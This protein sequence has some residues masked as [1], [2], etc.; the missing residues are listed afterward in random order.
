MLDMKINEIEKKVYITFNGYIST[1][2]AKSFLNK[3]KQETKGIKKSQYK[4]VVKPSVFE[5]ESEE[6]VKDICI[7]L[8][9]SGYQKI[10]MLD[11]EGY[12]F[13]TVPMSSFEKKMLM[14][15]VKFVKSD[16]EIK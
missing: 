14:K 6:D 5:C 1:S 16:R 11:P 4:L 9:K 2:E 15:V 3:H 12:I 10:Y 13:K 7:S 8:Y